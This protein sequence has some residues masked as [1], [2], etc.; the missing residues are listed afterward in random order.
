MA[1]DLM[2]FENGSK[3][4]SN[5]YDL[6]YVDT[7]GQA[8][9]VIFDNEHRHAKELNGAI[10]DENLRYLKATDDIVVFVNLEGKSFTVACD[11]VATKD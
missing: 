2:E 10:Y 8:T 1:L 5:G 7:K 9:D 3:L 11:E 4:V 6:T